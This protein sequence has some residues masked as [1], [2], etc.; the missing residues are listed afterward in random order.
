[1]FSGRLAAIRANVAQTAQE[2]DW[3]APVSILFATGPALRLPITLN[4]DQLVT[5]LTAFKPAN[6]IVYPNTLDALARHCAA[7]GIALEG[8]Q[9]IRT[10]GETLHPDV[11]ERAS[12]AFGARIADSYS[13]Q[14][15]GNIALQCPE[16][17]LYHTMAESLIVEV[18]DE[19][20]APCRAGQVGRIVATDLHNFATPL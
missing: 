8:L 14:E 3:G 12:Q 4:V 18:L 9:I 11:R 16:S 17:G 6:L 7:S 19:A 20:G 2:Q 15:L 5:H 1:D 13:S 10:I